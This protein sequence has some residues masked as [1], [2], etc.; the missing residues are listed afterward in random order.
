MS[1]TRLVIALL[2]V[3]GLVTF[4]LQNTSPSIPLVFLG[5]RTVALPLG[6]WLSGAIALGGLTTLLLSG[7]TDWQAIASQR[8]NRR[9]WQVRPNPASERSEP[10]GFRPPRDTS[11]DVRRE[12]PRRAEAASGRQTRIQTQT[13]SRDAASADNWEAWGQRTPASQWEDWSQANR[14]ESAKQGFSRR[15]RKDREKAE[16]AISDM[17]Q[18]WDESAQDTVYVPPGGSAVE[19]ALDEIAEGWEDWEPENAS[20][21]TAYSYGYQGSEAASRVDSIY[22]PPDDVR[23]KYPERSPTAAESDRNEDWGLD[24]DSERPQTEGSS[25]ASSH[26]EADGEGVYDADYRV[27]IPPHR[28]LEDAEDDSDRT[29]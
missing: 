22:A 10:A 11:R 17:S 19:D 29:P 1:T 20:A 5:I 6:V 7:L 15:Q 18:G 25:A 28:P 4:A 27:I 9:R 24:D 16:G 23:D 8:P 3:C 21:E 12:P 14:R 26:D 2:I 13:T